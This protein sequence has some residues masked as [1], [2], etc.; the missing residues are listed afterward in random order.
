[1]ESVFGSLRGGEGGQL[2]VPQGKRCEKGKS[3]LRDRPRGLPE[4]LIIGGG[5][6]GQG[7]SPSCT[8]RKI[9]RATLS[10]KIANPRRRKVKK[11]KRG[12]EKTPSITRI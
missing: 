9:A 6:S 3:S 7:A 10:A 1:V 8:E 2:R 12:G 11:R 4:S 5:K